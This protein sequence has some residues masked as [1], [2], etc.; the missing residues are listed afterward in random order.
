MIHPTAI[1]DPGAEIDSSVEIGPYT[2][3]KNH[4]T[5]G[6]DTVVGSHVTIDSY[7]D[8]GEACQIF[9]YASVGAAPQALKYEGEV[10]HARIGSRSVIR[11]FVTI[12]RG[13]N[14]GGGITEIGPDN[15]LMAYCH[16]AHDCRTGR[17]VILAN[18][19]TLAGHVLIGD[20]VTVGGLVAIHQFVR[21]GERAYLGGKSAIVKDIPPFVIASGD[22]AKLHGLNKVG[23]KRSGFTEET[24][25]AL[26]KTYR[27]VF[28]I[29]MTLNEAIERV[30]A[31]VDPLPEVIQFIDF[32]KSSE[33]GITR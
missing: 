22:R 8:I 33:R 16:V 11:E 4:V 32:L 26:K 7:T 19:A 9:Q 6:A 27:I 29:G 2:V 24:I 25:A 15:F 18:N 14:F 31:E 3:I 23:L 13:T 21:I 10:T 30:R 5:I 17:H 12:N 1:V 28:R 20:Y